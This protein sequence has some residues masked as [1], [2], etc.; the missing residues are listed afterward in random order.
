MITVMARRFPSVP[1]IIYPTALQGAFAAAQIVATLETAI[2]RDECDVLIIGRGGGSLEDMWP[3]NEEIV[4]R[5]I[6]SC[7]VPIVSAVGHE[8]DFTIADFVADLRAPTPSGAAELVVPDHADWLR[9]LVSTSSRIAQLARRYLEDRIQSTDW[10]SR[11][12]AQS[13]PAATVARQRDWLRNLRQVLIGVVRHDLSARARNMESMRSRLLQRSPALGVQQ[14]VSRLNSLENRLEFAGRKGVDRLTQQLSLATR[15]LNSVSPLA[16]LERGYA[17]VTEQESG[18]L[19]THASSVDA[20]TR[21]RARL[22]EGSLDATVTG[23]NEG[24]E[25]DDET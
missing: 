23:A 2:E 13:S 17:I 21:I 15:A 16:T 1:V 7:P 11:R 25:K 8:I 12:L 9:Q 6:A 14:T 10:L 20:G 19:L 3:F 22:A 18:K 4:A 24:D 5:A